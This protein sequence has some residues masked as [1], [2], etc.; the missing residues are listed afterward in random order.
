MYDAG[1]GTC[2]SIFTKKEANAWAGEYIG[3]TWCVSFSS[4]DVLLASGNGDGTINIWDVKTRTEIRA[5]EG[6][7]EV[8]EA[9]AFSSDGLQLASGSWDHSIRI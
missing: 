4:D 2:T 9:V 7:T 5:L 6:Y 8:M 3:C 1:T